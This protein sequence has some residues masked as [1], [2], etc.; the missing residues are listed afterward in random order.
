M[1]LTVLGYVTRKSAFLRKTDWPLDAWLS[2][3]DK[4]RILGDSTTWLGLLLVCVGGI[5]GAHFWPGHHL[6]ALSIL[7]Y[8]GHALG[9][10]I[11]RRIGIS[12]GAF[13]PGIDHGDYVLTAGLFLYLIGELSL[14]S[15]VFA[16]LLT[17]ILTPFITVSAYHV[18]VR[19]EAL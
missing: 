18:K 7:V 5:I 1:S 10:F 8:I 14:F 9:S 13:L 11:K 19:K 2:L 3:P 6:F 4:K 16:W 12:E 15:W 17:L